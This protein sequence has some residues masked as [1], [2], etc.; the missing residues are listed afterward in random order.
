M[1]VSISAAGGAP[2]LRAGGGSLGSRA[3]GSKAETST[4]FTFFPPPTSVP[5]VQDPPLG[6][7]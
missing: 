5:R 4:A 2:F 1:S 7:W 6:L 3:Q